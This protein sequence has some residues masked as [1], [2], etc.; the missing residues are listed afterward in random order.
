KD[1]K[2][3]VSPVA[4]LSGRI[5]IQGGGPIPRLQLRL[6]GP[7][8]EENWLIFNTFSLIPDADGRF[9]LILPEGDPSLNVDRLPS[10]YRLRSITYG[11]KDLQ[12]APL[13][14]RPTEPAEE[15]RIIL[16][17]TAATPLVTVSG[18]VTGLRESGNVRVRLDGTFNLPRE[19]PLNSDGSFVFTQVFQGRNSIRLVGD[20]ESATSP[21]V[22]FTAG[23]KD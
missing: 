12:R 18:R 6:M 7:S 10:G 16:E 13:R 2:L 1:L 23:T 15:L 9:N 14:I 5:V 11:P 17:K 22:S 19:I 4:K 3:P 21:A 8:A 20:V